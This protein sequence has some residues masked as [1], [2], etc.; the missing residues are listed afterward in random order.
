MKY[1][2]T[3]S[4][5]QFDMIAVDVSE[6]AQMSLW[7]MGRD[8]LNTEMRPEALVRAANSLLTYFGSKVS[9]TNVGWDEADNCFLWEV[10]TDQ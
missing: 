6:D 8:D 4:E 10:Q 9:I 2:D 7:E 1:V 3:I 5:R